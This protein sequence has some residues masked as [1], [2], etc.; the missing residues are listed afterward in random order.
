[1]GIRL[2]QVN[3]FDNNSVI[4]FDKDRADIR[5][6]MFFGGEPLADVISF[7]ADPNILKSN[8]RDRVEDMHAMTQLFCMNWATK[9]FLKKSLMLLPL[10]SAVKGDYVESII[11]SQDKLFKSTGNLGIIVPE[12]LLIP[13]SE[14]Y[15]LRSVVS[16]RKFSSPNQDLSGS[17][18]RVDIK[19]NRRRRGGNIEVDP[20]TGIPSGSIEEEE[21]TEYQIIP[22][23]EQFTYDAIEDMVV[24]SARAIIPRYFIS[25]DSWEEAMNY[26]ENMFKPR[27]RFLK[28]I[29]RFFT[30]SKGSVDSAVRFLDKELDEIFSANLAQ[31]K[32]K[33]D[34]MFSSRKNML[35]KKTMHSLLDG[36]TS[37]TTIYIDDETIDSNPEFFENFL[38]VVTR[39]SPSKIY[40]VLKSYANLIIVSKKRDFVAIISDRYLSHSRRSLDKAAY[41]MTMSKGREIMNSVFGAYAGNKDIRGAM[42]DYKNFLSTYQKSHRGL[43][44]ITNFGFVMKYSDA[45]RFY[46]MK[47]DT[48]DD[49]SK[50]MDLF[51]SKV[52]MLDSPT[53]VK[54]TASYM[55]NTFFKL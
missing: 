19:S 23:S 16:D 38:K 48:M 37:H 14:Q 9:F 5:I 32:D 33:G 27:S 30:S 15:K 28:T 7:V 4:L 51:S 6:A 11:K 21:N 8:N 22:S 50:M 29:E 52:K 34:D 46:K 36:T 49:Y 25:G 18:S 55:L 42:K 26:M 54:K 47:A 39:I 1:M 13:T 17:G 10:V 44:S 53:E 12:I 43:A 45:V 31:Y 40:D 35:F 3:D 41:E 20:V 24:I 2:P